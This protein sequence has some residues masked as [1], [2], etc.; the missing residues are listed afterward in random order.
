MPELSSQTP[1]QCSTPIVLNMTLYL[2]IFQGE[3]A[4]SGF[5]WHITSYHN[6]SE[7]LAAYNGADLHLDI[8]KASSWSW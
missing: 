7:H 6:S 5:D 1:D 2:D 3:P 8:L 4:I